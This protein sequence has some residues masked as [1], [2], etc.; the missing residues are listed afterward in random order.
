MPSA[1]PAP[2]ER[3]ETCRFFHRRVG[4]WS[5]CR[6]FPPAPEARGSKGGFPV[7]APDDWCGEHQ[8]E[9]Q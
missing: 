3:C 5:V 2:P 1:A 7:V 4:R 9:T 8:S 6:R